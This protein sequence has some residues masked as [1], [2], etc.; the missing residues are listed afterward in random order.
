MLTQL[1][2]RFRGLTIAQSKIQESWECPFKYLNSKNFW[3]IKVMSNNS[4]NWF[5]IQNFSCSK[6]QFWPCCFYVIILL[7]KHQGLPEQPTHYYTRVA[8]VGDKL[9]VAPE[10]H[11][12]LITNIIF[13]VTLCWRCRGW[14]EY[15]MVASVQY[16]IQIISPMFCPLTLTNPWTGMYG[17]P[18]CYDLFSL[19]TFCTFMLSAWN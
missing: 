3:Q 15:L 8:G 17:T 2:H 16:I 4:N 18:E 11:Q 12:L 19:F 14:T 1:L 10:P 5:N 6:M 13:C 9:N 7:I